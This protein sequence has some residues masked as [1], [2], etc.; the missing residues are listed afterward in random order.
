M[1]YKT[2]PRI[3]V[4]VLKVAANCISGRKLDS[5]SLKCSRAGNRKTVLCSIKKT[6]NE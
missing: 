2:G 6:V 5:H 1:F 4:L 3:H